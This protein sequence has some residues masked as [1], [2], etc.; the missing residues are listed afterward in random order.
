LKALGV[1]N[2]PGA[3]SSAPQMDEFFTN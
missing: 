3:S 2:Y 1:T